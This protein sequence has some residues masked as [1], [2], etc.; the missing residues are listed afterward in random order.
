MR[1][2]EF[3]AQIEGNVICIPE[4]YVD[5]FSGSRSARVTLTPIASH[6]DPALA[7]TAKNLRGIIPDDFD[8]DTMRHERIMKRARLEDFMELRIPTQGWKFDREEANAR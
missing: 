3:E 7:E 8:L 2:I 1:T 6:P 5:E 4:Q